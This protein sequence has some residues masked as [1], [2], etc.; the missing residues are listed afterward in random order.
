MQSPQQ[1]RR[2]L[3]YFFLFTY[4]LLL[5]INR[6]SV[7][8][9]TASSLGALT[10]G[11]TLATWLTYGLLYLL[12]A[13]GLT[14]LAERLVDRKH[15]TANSWVI[16]PIAICASS[17][18][19]LFIY[20]NGKLHEL[21]GIFV[22]SF[23]VNLL[24]T[25]GGLESMGASN[26]SNATFAGIA[27]GFVL[28]Q[29]LL[30][31]TAH[32]FYYKLGEP[33]WI[34]RHFF[35][36]LLI[37]F[38]ITSL[39]ERTLYA[40]C[41][42]TG[43]NAVTSLAQNVP[44]Y[45]S[46]TARGL[47]KKLGVHVQAKGQYHLVKG[48]LRYPL[49][50]LKFTKPAKPYNI[51]WL[52]SESWRADILDQEIMP[53]T[54]AFAQGGTRFLN[55]YSGGNGTRVGMFTLFTGIPGSYWF[56]FLDEHRGA[57]IIDVM[58]AEQYQMS[59]YTSAKFSYPEFDQTI[60]H[61]VPAE[62]LHTISEGIPGWKKDQIN[63]TNLLKFIDQRD[64][65]Q[66]FFT[67]MF[68]ESPHARYYF[69]PESVI[70]TPYPD[71]INY[72][73]LSHEELA[74]N[75]KLIKNRYINSVHHLDSQFGR[76]F[77]Y[78]KQNGLLDNTIVLMMGDHGEEFMENGRWGHNSD[79]S[80]QQIRTPLVLWVPGMKPAT[81]EGISSH[82]DMVP[83][84]M[85]LLGVTNPTADYSTG[86]NLL[87]KQ[88]R[89]STTIAEWQSAAYID[90]D[91]KIS[92]PLNFLASQQAHVTGSHDEPMPQKAQDAAFASKTKNIVQMM[93]DLGRYINKS[94]K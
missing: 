24:V 10:L 43:N 9:A 81:Y 48:H 49:S 6:Y 66:P 91:V 27:L 68:F 46:V 36:G 92:M 80:D 20:A 75:I 55:H 61:N 31:A 52:T 7:D 40:Y 14:L 85:P 12:P 15:E 13:L 53:N 69:P 41:E 38:V 78:L 22:N 44:F 39:G 93:Q 54:W 50:P 37:A 42:A 64:K 89:Q 62:Q 65:N 33:R 76:I 82:M 26:A 21:Y 19:T 4:L 84:L 83:T 60:F 86:I 94:P 25:P 18:T 74:S 5:W 32:F 77:D 59:F 87:S 29:M 34:P 79:F 1:L 73:T 2:I 45:L 47:L 51:V 3:S 88:A 8:F 28:L 16:Y 57:A 58:K 67:F 17:L 71:D 90:H 23:V 70:R 30:L 35:G 11:F 56:P 63:V 72:F